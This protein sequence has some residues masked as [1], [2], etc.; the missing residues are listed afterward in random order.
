VQCDT[1][2]CPELSVLPDVGDTMDLSSRRARGGESDRN[3]QVRFF[4]YASSIG[5][6]LDCVALALCKLLIR[7]KA[8]Q[9]NDGLYSAL[10]GSWDI[11]P[12]CNGT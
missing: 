7:K 5:S 9:G 6:P 4:V 11:S 3:Y 1:V 10:V 12:I 2:A 8:I